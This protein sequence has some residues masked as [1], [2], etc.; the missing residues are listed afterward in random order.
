[1]GIDQLALHSV[2]LG[3]LKILKMDNTDPNNTKVGKEIRGQASLDQCI[4]WQSSQSA[5]IPAWCINR[6]NHRSVIFRARQP[7][8]AR[9]RHS[10]PVVTT[11]MIALDFSGTTHQSASH[12]VAFNQVINQSVNQARDKHISRFHNI[13][14]SHVHTQAAKSAQFVP[15]TVDSTSTDFSQGTETHG[16]GY[17]LS[18]GSFNHGRSYPESQILGISYPEAETSGRTIKFHYTKK[19]ATSRSSPRSFY[20]LNWVTIRG[21]THKE[22]SATKFTQNNDG[23]RRQ[24]TEKSHGEQ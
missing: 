7:I 8:T 4:N 13:N 15:S 6:G 10:N 23:K 21:A 16:L 9:G 18:P 24:S 3:Y 20:S 22:S 19:P 5:S 1:M 2:Q 12:N 11:P 14:H 17:Q